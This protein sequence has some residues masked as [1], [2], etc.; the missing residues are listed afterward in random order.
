MVFLTIKKTS[1]RKK[2]HLFIFC[3][4]FGIRF[5]RLVS[6]CQILLLLRAGSSS[7][8]VGLP[9]FPSTLPSQHFL[10]LLL[11]ATGWWTKISQA[12]IQHSEVKWG[13]PLPG[14]LG[15]PLEASVGTAS[16]SPKSWW[17]FL[18][19]SREGAWLWTYSSDGNDLIPFL[20]TIFV[21]VSVYVYKYI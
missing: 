19:G 6:S 11:S 4:F 2:T 9:A 17:E 18:E 12:C 15:G 8:L 5:H 20:L 1:L 16:G 14:S 10:S 3:A 13:K 21:H 7:A